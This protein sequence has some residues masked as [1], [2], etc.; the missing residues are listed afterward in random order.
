MSRHSGYV[1]LTI[2][3]LL[4][5]SAPM[6]AASQNAVVYG[7]VYDAQGNPMAGVTVTLDNA[8]FNFSRTT[9][10]GSDGSYNFAEVPPADNYRITASRNGNKLD[11]R[12][13]I[14]VNVGDE[15]VILPPLK[16]QAAVAAAPAP[17]PGAKPA[18]AAPAAAAAE[19]PTV[20]TETVATSISGVITREQL[21]SLPLYNRNFL[22]LGLI[23]PNVHDTQAFSPV[24]GATFSV[25]G[26]RPEMNSFLLDGTDNVASLTNQAVPFQVNDSIQEFRVI[27]SA[28]NAEYGR[29]GGGTVN[30]VT[31]RASNSFHG[32]AYGYFGNDVLNGESALSVYSN[33]GFAKAAAYAGSLSSA[34]LQ[35]VPGATQPFSPTTYNEYVATAQFVGECTDSIALTGPAPAGSVPCRFGGN[36]FNHQFDAASVLANN[37][38]KNIPFDSKQFGVNMGG[39]IL[40][41]KLFAFGSFEG[42][43]ID[44][45]TPIFERVPST[46]DRTFDPLGI[47]AGVGPYTPI[48][49]ASGLGA[50]DP[51]F[52]LG[53]RIANLFPTPNVIGV[54]NALEFFKGE[55]PNFT[56]VYNGLARLDYVQSDKS[57]WTG[58]FVIQHLDQLAGDTLPESTVYPGNGEFRNALNMN[59]DIS[60]NHT[61]SSNLLNSV[62]GGFTRFNLDETAQ[63]AHF[64]ATTLGLPSS[65]M[66]T[67]VLSGLSPMYSGGGPNVPGAYDSWVDAFLF[68]GAVT[69]FPT[70]DGLFPMARIGAPLTAPASRTDTTIFIGD[71]LSWTKGKHNLKFGFEYRH[72]ENELLN[73]A[74]SRGVVLSSD[75]GEFTN[76]ATVC[77]GCETVVFHNGPSAYNAPSYDFALRQPADYAGDFTYHALAFFA[78]DTW[79]F[80]P[81]FTLNIG[82]RYEYFGVPNEANNQ[83]WNYDP[84]ANGLVQHGIPNQ[85]LDPYGNACTGATGAVYPNSI[86][87]TTAGF[88]NLFEGNPNIWNCQTSGSDQIARSNYLNFAPRIGLAWDVSGNG[89]TVVRVGAGIYYDQSA[90]NTITSLLY[91]R[92]TKLSTTNPQMIY[93]TAMLGSQCAAFS[94]QCSYG[95]TTLNPAAAGFVPTDQSAASPFAVLARDVPNTYTPYVRQLTVTVQH[96]LTNNIVIEGGYVGSTGQRLPAVFNSGFNNEWFCTNSNPV[97]DNFQAFPVFTMTNLAK[98][99]YHSAMVR[100]RMQG[101]HGLRANLTYTWSRAMDNQSTPIYPT[102]PITLFN[103]V[104][105]AFTGQFNLSLPDCVVPGFLG[106]ISGATPSCQGAAGIGSLGQSLAVTTTGAGAV[107]TTPYL[108]PQDP[109]SFLQNDWGRSDFDTTHRLVVDYTYD[110]PSLQKK[111]GW[112][113]WLDYWQLSG[114]VIAQTGQPFT[115]YSG[116][117]FGELTQRASLS[118]PV[119]VTSNPSTGIVSTGITLASAPCEA[120]ASAPGAF[121]SPFISVDSSNAGLLLS[122]TAGAPCL[123]NS[124]RNAFV[125]PAYVNV[126]FAVQKGFPVFGEGKWLYLRGEFYNIFNRANLY[127]PDSQL[128]FDGLSLNPQFGQYLSAHDPRQIQLSLRFSW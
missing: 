96:Q 125:G 74:F 73:G 58:R 11:V 85:V 95:N 52:V 102:L 78:Q 115:I 91:N 60:F 75:I 62:Y 35:T 68:P 118:A 72:L 18:P 90:A 111:W 97:C 7:T 106:I 126:N 33:S 108:I 51:N 69:M 44:N 19:A 98:S 17:A 2:V 79:R 112:S 22:Y 39:P 114:I 13:G 46:F 124:A 100:M 67:F 113:K 107:S 9:T 55:A 54:P 116:P 70:L 123:G 24:A 99:V 40:K 119:H 122:G 80:H 47:G 42:T 121:G 36:G 104:N 29:N 31:R 5:L 23:T 4:L 57:N 53:N 94:F 101:W 127:N 15:R 34:P 110:V 21:Q 105:A 38:S 12:S 30:V 66:P 64:D 83:V 10:T 28:G 77:N 103:S 81:R 117:V 1:V 61:I 93:G 88:F 128:S 3:L 50:S 16:E 59:L 37:D 45:P 76:D 87:P 120:A 20:T 56:N 8:A 49:F 6:F 82:L 63:D 43:K 109:S 65:Q 25:A 14:S 86:V 71:N 41:D 32:S 92:P 84:V 48:T 26:N 27:S 89:K